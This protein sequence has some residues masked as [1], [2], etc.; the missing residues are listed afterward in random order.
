[1]SKACGCRLF[2]LAL[3]ELRPAVSSGR[4]AEGTTAGWRRP[5]LAR[6]AEPTE[7]PICGSLSA[8]HS[9]RR[10]GR[11][12]KCA[13]SPC[14]SGVREGRVGIFQRYDH[15]YRFFAAGC[16]GSRRI[17]DLWRDLRVLRSFRPTITALPHGDGPGPLLDVAGRPRLCSLPGRLAKCG[18]RLRVQP[19]AYRK[20]ID[21][22]IVAPTRRR[23]RCRACASDQ[24]DL[25]LSSS[26]E[27]SQGGSSGPHPSGRTAG[28]P[29]N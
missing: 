27:G 12:L 21:V 8:E 24:R 11:A 5:G 19:A 10:R 26:E 4:R 13:L 18:R 7:S 6:N 1:M 29:R 14:F 23:G 17:T 20:W 9:R 22:I 3:A 15:M 25:R 28:A 16:Q 2:E